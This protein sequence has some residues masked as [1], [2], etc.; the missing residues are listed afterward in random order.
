MRVSREEFTSQF[1]NEESES[2][3]DWCYEITG[4]LLSSQHEDRED[5][6]H[7]EDHLDNDTLRDAR[8]RAQF[9]ADIE[10]SS[11]E[12]V[13]NGRGCDGGYNLGHEE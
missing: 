5:Q 3:A 10:T 4:V 11:E 13:D 12:S 1:C 8:G 2:D 7:C 6:R 9:S